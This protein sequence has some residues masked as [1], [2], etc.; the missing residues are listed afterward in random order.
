MKRVLLLGVLLAL[1]GCAQQLVWSKSGLTQE[2]FARDRYA[3]VL[4]SRSYASSGSIVS[5]SYIP[6][7]GGYSSGEVIDRNVL[8][9]CMESKGY[10]LINAQTSAQTSAAT[11]SLVAQFRAIGEKGKLCISAVRSKAEYQELVP[12]LSDSSGN[13]SLKQLSDSSLPTPSEARAIVAYVDEANS[14]LGTQIQEMTTLNPTIALI[15][16]QRDEAIQDLDLLV[17]ERKVTWGEFAQKAKQ[18]KQQW[19]SQLSQVRLR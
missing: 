12:H 6:L 7:S 2:E 14:C 19:L 1:T 5:T 17:A 4:Q 16:R 10:S 11:Q 9:P 18:I 13:Y 3:C 15:T 8:N